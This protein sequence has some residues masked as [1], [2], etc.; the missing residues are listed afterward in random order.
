MVK[1]HFSQRIDLLV[2]PLIEE[3]RSHPD[4]MHV[5]TILV[6]NGLVKQWL[7]LEIAKRT[8]IAMGMKILEPNQLFPP[9][10]TPLQRFCSL[11]TA[12]GK[13]AELISYIDGK[14][15]RRLELTNQLCSL[16]AKYEQHASLLNTPNDWQMQLFAAPPEF[17]TQEHLICFGIDYLPLFETPS[18][19]IYQFSPC[20]EF[21]ED[22]FSD[23]ERKYWQ[24]KGVVDIYMREGPRNLANWGKL[25]RIALKRWDDFELEEHYASIEP[26][27]NLKQIQYD[28]LHF[29]E[30]KEPKTD[31]SIQILQTGSSRL[32]EIEA[33]REEILRLDV[34]FQDISVLAPDIEPYVPLIEFVFGDDIPFRIHGIDS[35]AESSFKH[36]LLRLLQLNRWEAEEILALIETP[37][38]Y[39]KKGW[40]AETL[41]TFREWIENVKIEW[42]IDSDHRTSILQQ[43]L[44]A[45]KSQSER[46]WEK[47][48][49]ALLEKI[50]YLKPMQVNPD[51]F[52]ELLSTLLALKNLDLKGEKTLPEW[53]DAIQKAADEFLIADAEDLAQ[54]KAANLLLEMRKSTDLEKYP[55]DIPMHFL[56]A[57]SYGQMNGSKLH[58][59]RFAPIS[60]GAM[61]P[62]KALFLIGMDEM[63]FPRVETPSSLDLLRGKIPSKGDFDRYAFLQAIFSAKDYLRISYGH[64]SAE[65]GKPVGPSLVVQE[66]LNVVS[67]VKVYSPKKRPDPEKRLHLPSFK[68]TALPEG[69]ITLSIQELRKLAR[70]PWKFFLQKSHK[71]FLDDE[72]EDSFAL[73]KGK[74]T[75]EL[76]DN[77][78]VELP[79]PFKTAMELEVLEK[80]HERKEQLKKWQLEPFTLDLQLE[81][82]WEKCKINLVGEIKMA[83]KQGIISLN[84][85]NLA[86]TL[87]IWPEA[88]AVASMLD[89]PQIWMLRNGKIKTLNR[90]LE[91]LKA[92]VEYYFHCLQAP[93]PLLPDWADSILRKKDRT[94]S[95]F[96]DPVMEWVLS[97]AELPNEEDW[98]PLL[99]KTFQG[100]IDLYPSRGSEK[101]ANISQI[102]GLL[103]S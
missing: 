45:V 60:E 14:K 19:S 102:N 49:D 69:E 70:H 103:K 13:N 40:D 68:D 76:T 52:E 24:R 53:A 61:L 57:P 66:L 58:A 62:A 32:A 81:L 55:I 31:S 79:G 59:V 38:F 30:T 92:F 4:P 37:S 94:Q 89:A 34:P 43:T 3:L 101:T 86:G 36:G 78:E 15:K 35:S 98:T 67:N 47:G 8:G 75:R 97:R 27:T 46:S 82:V 6:P 21:W 39:R 77:P 99:Q 54:S 44:G 93:S 90:P 17:E 72:L 64:L 87:K 5:Q 18:L 29:Q 20:T 71:I 33:L 84:D 65:E 51:L 12:I 91:Q 48:L 83:S 95:Q 9:S 41:E 2:D 7:L 50:V 26:T 25:G 73:Q 100:L 28:L 96:E 56:S 1:I 23:R 63:S 88:L 11:F 42:G 80:V 22:I 74:L 10:S 85:D 16:F